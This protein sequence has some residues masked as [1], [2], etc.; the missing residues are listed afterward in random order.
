MNSK[1][2][3]RK[4]NNNSSRKLK[5]GGKS[6]IEVPFNSLTIDQLCQNAGYSNRTNQIT[7]NITQANLE[8][9]KG[10]LGGIRNMAGRVFWLPKKML[11]LALN[12][13]GMNKLFNSN[14]QQTNNQSYNQEYIYNNSQNENDNGNN[15]N[16]INNSN[17]QSNSNKLNCLNDIDNLCKSCSSPNDL[18]HI[19][20]KVVTRIKGLN[21]TFFDES[22]HGQID[23]LFVIKLTQS[24]GKIKSNK[25]NRKKY[26]KKSIKNK[27]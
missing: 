25:K 4:K 20:N 24:G 1:K 18:I 2:K 21:K 23:N 15:I 12:T 17:N 9:N 8:E 10:M 6:N 14:D 22:H 11:N 3:I 7:N 19:H 13:T 26:N 5:G 16:N 27:K